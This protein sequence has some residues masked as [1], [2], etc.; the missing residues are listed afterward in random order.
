M[1]KP[2]AIIEIFRYLNIECDEKKLHLTPARYRRKYGF[3]WLKD[4]VNRIA[5]TQEL[6]QK[7]LA[8]L[9]K[10]KYA[11]KNHLFIVAITSFFNRF[12]EYKNDLIGLETLKN[13]LKKSYLEALNGIEKEKN[14]YIFTRI[15]KNP[16]RWNR[17]VEQIDTFTGGKTE[18]P[19]GIIYIYQRNPLKNAG[20]ARYKSKVGLVSIPFLKAMVAIRDSGI[21][22]PIKRS[23][24]KKDT[25]TNISF[26]AI[27][28]FLADPNEFDRQHK[29]KYIPRG[30]YNSKWWDYQAEVT[31]KGA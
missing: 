17:M 5:I 25:I 31:T 2:I 15:V 19:Y 23:Y 12:S 18:I 8:K 22:T 30:V 29:V 14:L 26:D 24:R 6:W 10:H 11:N 13:R 20:Y 28:E 9:E 16:S 4:S 7:N 27:R 3:K 21:L 1:M